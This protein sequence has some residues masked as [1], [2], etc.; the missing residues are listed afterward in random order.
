[1]LCSLISARARNCSNGSLFDCLPLALSSDAS[2]SLGLGYKDPAAHI[3]STTSWYIPSTTPTPH[4]HVP[5]AGWGQPGF[6]NPGQCSVVQGDGL[7]HCF[8]SSRSNIVFCWK[9]NWAL[10]SVALC[11]IPLFS[12]LAAKHFSIWLWCQVYL[13]SYRLI[14]QSTRMCLRLAGA[15]HWRY[16]HWGHGEGGPGFSP[17]HRYKV[18]WGGRRGP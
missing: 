5:K 10:R 17:S 14:I 1:M 6:P 2:W 4:P 13:P 9:V 8:S 7:H 12:P 16:H 3:H 18:V 11:D 15:A